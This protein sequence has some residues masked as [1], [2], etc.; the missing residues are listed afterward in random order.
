MS[1]IWSGKPTQISNPARPP[2]LQSWKPN[3][4]TLPVSRSVLPYK[5]EILAILPKIDKEKYLQNVQKLSKIQF[6]FKV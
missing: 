1:L 2:R 5:N 6:P 3:Q 4:L